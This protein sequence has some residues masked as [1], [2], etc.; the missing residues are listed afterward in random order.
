[1]FKNVFLVFFLIINV[2]LNAKSTIDFNANCK[3]AYIQ[4]MELD[5]SAS[6]Q[7]LRNENI[8]Q[9]ENLI[10]Q[11]ISVYQLFIKSMV[12]ESQITI[13]LYQQQ[14][15][16]VLN[17]FENLNAST[18]PW[19]NYCISDIYI[20]KTFLNFRN[21][22]YM[23]GV[24]C[25]RKAMSALES[26][27]QMFPGFLPNKKIGSLL[28]IGFGSVP[29]QYT[30]ILSMFNIN[31]SVNQGFR[32]L[33]MLTSLTLKN[34]A[35]FFL[36]NECLLISSFTSYNF[37]AG[38]EKTLSVLKILE[39]DSLEDFVLRSPFMVFSKMSLYQNLK[40]NEKALQCFFSYRNSTKEQKFHYLNFMVGECM[41]NKLDI[42]ARYYFELYLANFKGNSYKKAA[43][44]KI[45]W[46]ELLK[47][48][49]RNYKMELQ[50]IANMPQTIV[51]AD[52]QAVK[53]LKQNYLPDLNLLKS[54]LLFDGGYYKEA[55]N[56]LQQKGFSNG[57]NE[58]ET[59]E[60]YYRQARVFHEIGNIENALF[61]YRKTIEKGG[62]LS[63]YFA[64]NA[65]LQ[66]GFIYEEQ[67]NKIKAK[68][69]FELCLSFDYDEYQNSISQKAKAGLNR[70]EKK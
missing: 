37:S 53:E 1:M 57:F 11:Y 22:S 21:Q 6:D 51:D 36:R 13:N 42:T 27:R 30:W 38:K 45:A 67:R 47:G 15:D 52:K 49:Q 31:A 33:E 63:Y 32:D 14:S 7:L 40:Q 3:Q 59:L 24:N 46:I 58:K 65:A 69:M 8:N 62:N 16:K 43:Q 19:I 10:P 61:Y 41:L 23:S 2:R 68:E 60:F 20:Q 55:I 29:S 54:R 48:N 4:M 56:L 18:S 64:A 70:L 39:N 50:K 12:D 44:Q 66:S 26:N 25:L 34:P 9:K 17:L 5:F 35:Y 28:H